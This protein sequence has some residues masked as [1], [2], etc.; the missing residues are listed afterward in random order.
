MKFRF[1]DKSILTSPSFSRMK[2]KIVDSLPA[3]QPN[4][5]LILKKVISSNEENSTVVNKF[6][7]YLES[8][9]LTIIDEYGSYYAK[10]RSR[11][12]K[13]YTLESRYVNWANVQ[14]ADAT[15]RLGINFTGLTQ[16]YT[17]E[18]IQHFNKPSLDIFM[19]PCWKCFH[20][21]STET[22]YR[23]DSDQ[24]AQWII[25]NRVSTLNI[26]GS[27]NKVMHDYLFQIFT[28]LVWG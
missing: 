26:V 11:L 1:V 4:E 18:A 12:E 28:T 5:N 10:N 21:G 24:V 17:L 19:E 13:L 25:V 22:Q 7:P 6:N 8:G 15:I 2:V 23:L 9:G 3:L 27:S 14:S 20:E 16:I